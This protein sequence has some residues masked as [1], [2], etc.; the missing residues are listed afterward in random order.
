MRLVSLARSAR[1]DSNLKI[2]QPLA[3]LVIVPADDAERSAVKRFEDHFIEELNV[4]KLTLR[5]NREGLF[6]VTVAPNMK[7]LGAKFGRAVAAAKKVIESADALALDAQRTRG[8]TI[9][10]AMA[11]GFSGRDA[12][13]M[14]GGEVDAVLSEMTNMVCGNFLSRLDGGKLYQLGP[15]RA[16]AGGADAGEAGLCRRFPVEGGELRVCVAMRGHE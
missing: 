16:V 11:A 14:E 10:L 13:E 15:P 6:T 12:D 4:K 8:E 2:R 9:A 3:E 7:T 5:E 1:K